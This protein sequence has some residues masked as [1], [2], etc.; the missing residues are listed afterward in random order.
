MIVGT[1]QA[2]KGVLLTTLV[3]QSILR[4]DTV[5]ILDPKNSSRLA[6]AVRSAAQAVHRDDTIFFTP[7]ATAP[8]V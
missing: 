8:S 1:T 7:A 4:G 5:I 2:G 6:D 3:A